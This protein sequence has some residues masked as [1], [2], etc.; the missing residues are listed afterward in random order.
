MPSSSSLSLFDRTL[1]SLIMSINIYYVLV[2]SWS[3]W[4]FYSHSWL[5]FCLWNWR[6]M[7][8]NDFDG[9]FCVDGDTSNV[10][11][12]C[13]CVDLNG[14]LWNYVQDCVCLLFMMMRV[15]LKFFEIIW[16]L[17]ALWGLLVGNFITSSYKLV[18]NDKKYIKIFLKFS[19][20]LKFMTWNFWI[21]QK[22]SHSFESFATIL[23]SCFSFF[24]EF[25]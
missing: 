3:I 25:K 10:M 13:L 1:R 20:N 12:L 2:H 7:K 19:K 14:I 24:T 9:I 5:E 17:S 4:I 16:G 22:N 21:F 23:R 15:S 18:K 8:S 11:G 6:R